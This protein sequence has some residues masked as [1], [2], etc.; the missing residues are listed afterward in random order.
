MELPPMAFVPAAEM[1]LG[2]DDEAISFLTL[3]VKVDLLLAHAGITHEQVALA[4]EQRLKSEI[5]DA[6]TQL[7]SLVGDE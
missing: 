7:K 3:M 5:R 2:M 4:Y 1:T 6:A